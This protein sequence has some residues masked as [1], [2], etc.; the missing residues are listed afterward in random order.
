MS[1][2]NKKCIWCL[3]SIDISARTCHHCGKDQSR[4][5]GHSA[6]YIVILATIAFFGSGYSWYS[7]HKEAS[8]AEQAVAVAEEASDLARRANRSAARTSSNLTS[9]LGI[10]RT[11]TNILSSLS[12]DMRIDK[13]E[14]FNNTFN[15]IMDHAAS[16][17]DLGEMSK[18][19]K[20][21][22][23][24]LL[25]RVVWSAHDMA[26]MT[27]TSDVDTL[28]DACW[29]IDL[30]LDSSFFNECEECQ[31]WN[32][33]VELRIFHKEQNCSDMIDP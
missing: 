8:R 20:L 14:Q 12:D 21:G 17:G 1:D 18:R 6:R 26:D 33:T 11:Q 19:K 7:A 28:L 31:D 23:E 24:A 27:D 2:S 32:E 25:R 22:C 10:I 3:Q 5:V 9:T 15:R 30:V 29:M 13:T 4:F 16:C